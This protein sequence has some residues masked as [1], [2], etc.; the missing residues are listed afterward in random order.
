MINL[1]DF[2]GSVCFKGPWFPWLLSNLPIAFGS[3]LTHCKIRHLINKTNQLAVQLNFFLIL[4]SARSNCSE[5][6]FSFPFKS[7]EETCLTLLSVYICIR[8]STVFSFIPGISWLLDSL[9]S[10]WREPHLMPLHIRAITQRA[11]VLE[12]FLQMLW[13]PHYI[14]P[15]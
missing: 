1:Q 15:Q 10:L 12:L 9:E 6:R 5:S 8:C 14:A 13:Q 2:S 11:R 3:N 7:W 4:F